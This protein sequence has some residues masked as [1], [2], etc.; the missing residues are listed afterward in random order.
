MFLDKTKERNPELIKVALSLHSSG[1]IAP[2]TYVID[3][4]AVEKNAELLADAARD[5]G[6]ELYMMTKQ[7]GRNPVV[8][9]KIAGAGIKKAVAVDPWEA[10]TLA[11]AGIGLGNVGN[12]VQIPTGMLQAILSYRPEVMTVFTV[13]KARE[14]SAAAAAVGIKQPL[15]LRVV[16]PGDMVYE[17]QVGGFG[18]DELPQ[19]AAEIAALPNVEISGVTAFPCFLFNT[20]TDK[21]EATS[22]LATVL[23]GA[24]LLTR[25]GHPIQQINTPSNTCVSTIPLLAK[26]GA[27]HGEPGHALTGTTPLHSGHNQAELPA[28][29]YVSEVSHIFGQEAFVYG[30]GFYSRSRVQRALVGKDW[31]EL[32]NNCL[33]AQAVPPEYIDYYGVLDL[34]TGKAEVGDTVIFSFRTQI[35]VTRAQVALVGGVNQGR[36]DLLGIYD[37]LGREIN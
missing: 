1:A 30:G 11:R 10:L 7:M 16:A 25:L 4:D 26:A 31:E 12:L 21:V 32:R 35:F 27:T 5:H 6:I 36:P 18:L 24:E 28:I 29:V 3:V 33:M 9:A 2:N 34:S 8:A 22:N 19:A 13:A 20:D 14:V 17:G 23:K 37:N 15:L